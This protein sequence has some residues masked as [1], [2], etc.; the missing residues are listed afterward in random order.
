MK[1]S[2]GF[3][4]HFANSLVFFCTLTGYAFA[5]SK[6]VRDPNAVPTGLT[7]SDWSTIRALHEA[8]RHAIA[9]SE[10][11]YRAHNPG[12]Q[13][14]TEFDGRGFLTRPQKG[15]WRWGLELRSYGFAGHE[16]SVG[17]SVQGER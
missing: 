11:G 7:G 5:A 12:Q 16:R 9:P 6:P 4:A 17:T 3:L 15:D 8:Q 10:A 2:S 1:L 14:Q 13:W